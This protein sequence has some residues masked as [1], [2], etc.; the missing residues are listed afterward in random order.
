MKINIGGIDRAVR[1]V[2]GVV[3]ISFVYVGPQSVLGWLGLVPL[4]SSVFRV[5]PFYLLFGIDT[6]RMFGVDTCSTTT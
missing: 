2:A 4:V 3:L 1:V 5:C 6:C